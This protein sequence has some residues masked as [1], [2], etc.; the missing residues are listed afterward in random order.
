[1]QVG[2]FTNKIHIF[3]SGG[4]HTGLAH[5][6]VAVPAMQHIAVCICMHLTDC[7]SPAVFAALWQQAHLVACAKLCWRLAAHTQS[8]KQ[9]A[10]ELFKRAIIN[11]RE[12]I[13]DR[14]DG[15][16]TIAHPAA[17]TIC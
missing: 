3:Q 8:I 12:L 9:A 6:G 7:N 11:R 10:V 2:L 15:Q 17:A 4:A 5:T 1:M 16:I 14:R 13:E